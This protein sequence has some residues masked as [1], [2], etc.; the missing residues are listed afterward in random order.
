M[1]TGTPCK[2]LHHLQG[3]AH[4]WSW[5]DGQRA[6]RSLLDPCSCGL[7]PA[8]L[9]LVC[10]SVGGSCKAFK[11][12]GWLFISS[13][14]LA[15]GPVQ[16]VLDQGHLLVEFKQ[17]VAVT[18]SWTLHE[19]VIR[20]ACPRRTSARN[21]R[22]QACLCPEARTTGSPST[23]LPECSSGQ[24]PSDGIQNVYKD[25]TCLSSLASRS[26]PLSAELQ[27]HQP[28]LRPSRHGS[29]FPFQD[30]PMPGPGWL[31]MSLQTSSAGPA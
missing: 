14:L 29:I 20:G 9:W 16:S 23:R 31:G 12:P 22:L 21:R 26:P 24:W 28:C 6:V 18:A 5:D 15:L 25:S 11:M 2:S 19:F 13:Q 3:G 17:P 10:W 1:G 30:L 27:P 4:T 7:A 8:G